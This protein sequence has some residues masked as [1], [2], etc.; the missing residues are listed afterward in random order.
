MEISLN[1]YLRYFLNYICY[2]TGTP[3]LDH[4]NNPIP[5]AKMLATKPLRSEIQS[6][7]GHGNSRVSYMSTDCVSRTLNDIFGFDGWTSEVLQVTRTH[8][9]K[10]AKGQWLIV[11]E[12]KVRCTH[13][14]SGAFKEDI[15]VADSIHGQIQCAI[16]NAIKAAVSDGLKRAARHFGDKLGNILYNEKFKASNAP[17]TLKD[18]LTQ[19]EIERAKSKFGFNNERNQNS[20]DSTDATDT[21]AVSNT[22]NAN[23]TVEKSSNAS[24]TTSTIQANPT[25]LQKTNVNQSS[26]SKVQ[27]SYANTIVS[28]TS[29]DPLSST[30]SSERPQSAS[31]PS[32]TRQMPAVSMSVSGSEGNANSIAAPINS[33]NANSNGV[34]RFQRQVNPPNQYTHGYS[35]SYASQNSHYQANGQSLERPVSLNAPPPP[36]FAHRAR[37][38]VL[39]D[40]SG[41][42]NTSSNTM[43]HG[44][45]SLSSKP[46]TC[47]TDQPSN[48]DT[49][50]GINL[51]QL[52]VYSKRKLELSNEIPSIGAQKKMNANPYSKK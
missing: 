6:R 9:E 43:N 7:K 13:K 22:E 21:K 32:S 23:R 25:S 48:Q 27:P 39:N 44:N 51:N 45:V 16:S 41:T 28:N 36:P 33:G 29:G 17:L 34:P 14:A 24:V 52:N 37:S 5:I 50:N 38:E 26:N 11:Y 20:T 12:A 46:M 1:L 10:N 47:S 15:G 40:I 49:T 8:M 2:D 3:L 31:A 18:A 4:N 42:I 35:S 30:P 19:Y